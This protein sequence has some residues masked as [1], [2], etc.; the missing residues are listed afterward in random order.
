MTEP[1]H[2]VSNTGPASTETHETDQSGTSVPPEAENASQGNREE[3]FRKERNEARDALATAEER[4]QRMQR[5]EV[6]RLASEH[7]AVGGD[8]FLNGNDVASYVDEETG[9]VDAERVAEDARLL[10]SERPRLGKPPRGFDPSQGTGGRP[11]PKPE[12]SFATMIFDAV[13]Q[14]TKIS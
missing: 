5:A 9:E 8:L 2:D 13:E 10:I 7:L 12:I 11:Q 1:Q 3:R 14:H 6:E 4:I